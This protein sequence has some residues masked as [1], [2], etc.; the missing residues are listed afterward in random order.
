LEERIAACL[1]S[2]F[3]KQDHGWQ[4]PFGCGIGG[5]PFEVAVA[6]VDGGRSSVKAASGDAHF[7]DAD[8]ETP[9]V[10]SLANSFEDEHGAG[11]AGDRKTLQDWAV[12]P[13]E[14]RWNSRWAQRMKLTMR[15]GDFLVMV[16][17]GRFEDLCWD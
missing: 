3:A 13:R 4:N 8:L 9:L 17:R 7:S 14:Q 2:G 12:Q 6:S 16:T 15:D 11:V 10:T 5:C 1:A